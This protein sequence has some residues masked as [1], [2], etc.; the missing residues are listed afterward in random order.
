MRA[1]T[2]T[3]G[4]PAP[5]AIY[6]GTPGSLT[7]L[8]CGTLRLFN[9]EAG[10]TY[11]FMVMTGLGI[12]GIQLSL[13]VA[14]PPAND[15]IENAT[16]ITS[17]PFTNPQTM[18]DATR[19][20]TDPSA[21]CLAALPT[22]WYRYEAP[23]DACFGVTTTGGFG[24]TVVYEGSPGDLSERCLR[25]H[26]ARPRHGRID[27]LRRTHADLLAPMTLDVRLA[28][29]PAND[30]IE[31]ATPITSLPFTNPQTMADA[32]A[33]RHRPVGVVPWFCRATCAASLR[34]AGG[35][36][37]S[38]HHDGRVRVDGRLRG[39]AR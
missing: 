9:V 7:G 3:N 14:T 39:L 2:V 13:Q 35:R 36:A 17:L 12:S 37:R 16:P 34:G 6:E 15:L 5:V 22:V 11:Y 26:V 23:A 19:S 38:R 27:L 31:N 24:S 29:P 21:S 10:H 20:G 18:A 25:T 1:S 33:Q 8:G 4:S 32:I 30:L 28:T